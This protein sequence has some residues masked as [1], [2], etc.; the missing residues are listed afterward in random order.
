[1]SFIVK[2]RV[3]WISMLLEYFFIKSRRHGSCWWVAIINPI[4]SVWIH[5][6]RMV[7]DMLILWYHNFRW[8]PLFR[9]IFIIVFIILNSSTFIKYILRWCFMHHYSFCIILSYFIFIRLLIMFL[10]FFTLIFFRIRW[11]TIFFII[12]WVSEIGFIII[13]LQLRHTLI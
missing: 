13:F 7:M 10:F 6:L 1:M 12:I 4:I 2:F 11:T 5:R 8:S 3:S 9:S